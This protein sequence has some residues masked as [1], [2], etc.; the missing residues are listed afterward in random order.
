M[1]PYDFSCKHDI[2]IQ[3]EHGS[4]QPMDEPYFRAELVAPQTWLVR[5]DGDFT[6]LVEGETEAVV[7]DSGYGCGN[8]RQFCQSLTGKPVSRILNTHEH[9]DH[10]AN[11]GY[12]DCAYLSAAALPNATRPFPSFD[13]IEFPRDYRTQVIGDGYVFDLGGRTLETFE[14]GDHTLGSLVFLDRKYGILFSGDEFMVMGK[15]LRGS[16]ARWERLLS[17]L[18]PHR[19]EFQMLLA[20]GGKLDAALF[21]KQLAACRRILA[22][23]EGAPVQPFPPR[24]PGFLP[25]PEGLGRTIIPRYVPHPGDGPRL[26]A[27]TSDLRT[28]TVD[29]YGLTYNLK[30]KEEN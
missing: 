23:E 7:I 6:Y 16:V 8:I 29:G 30:K 18:E 14:I 5:S 10:T 2:W 26:P 3:D 25:D 1:K 24:R 9:F 28:V 13:G 22:G 15:S 20:G 19:G 4:L 27:D 17:K 11:N 21:D 12:F